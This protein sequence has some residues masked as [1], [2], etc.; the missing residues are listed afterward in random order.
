MPVRIIIMAKTPLAGYAKTRL[1]PALGETGAAALAARML[2]HSVQ[3]VLCLREKIPD[4]E[5]ELCVAPD[6]DADF[7]R[8]YRGQGIQLVQQVEGDLGV[9]MQTAAA[10]AFNAGLSPILMGTDCPALDVELLAQAVTQ[11]LQHKTVICP[12]F[13]GGYALLGLSGMCTAVFT[14]MPWSTAQVYK[15]TTERL[16]QAQFI[17]Y[18]LPVQHD[19]DEA[20]DLAFLAKE[21]LSD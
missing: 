11:V 21:W 8:V 1:I 4:I 3:Q 14:D 7:W 9:R 20:A 12:T 13:D 10:R 18:E 15:L 16:L 17:L 5:I 2:A 6:V 19:I